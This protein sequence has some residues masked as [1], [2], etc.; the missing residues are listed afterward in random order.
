MNLPNIRQLVPHQGAMVLLDRLRAVDQDKLCAEIDILPET[1]FC[2][3]EGVPGWI[4]IEYMAQAI[5]AHA[6]YAAYLR[7][8]PIKLGFLL[9]TRRYV[10]N[11]PTFLVGSVLHVHV[12]SALQADNGLGAFECRITDGASGDMIASATITVYQPE[13]VHDFLQRSNQ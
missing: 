5:A 3:D 4:G 7:G 6:G 2:Q 1:L 13:N 8:E 11:Q 10:C 12:Q 9:G